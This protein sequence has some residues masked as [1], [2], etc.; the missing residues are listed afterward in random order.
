M[1]LAVSCISDDDVARKEEA[2]VG[3]ELQ[4]LER[5][6]RAA[7]AENDIGRVFGAELLLEGRL[8]VGFA[9]K[10]QLAALIDRSAS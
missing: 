2:E 1:R 4:G 8:E 6:A 10:A 3:L 7:R 9:P 5:V